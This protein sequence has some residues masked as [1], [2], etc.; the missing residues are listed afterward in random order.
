MRRIESFCTPQA[1]FAKAFVTSISFISAFP[2]CEIFP[3][4]R[5]SDQGA[6]VVSRVPFCLLPRGA[7]EC[8]TC[9]PLP[10]WTQSLDGVPLRGSTSHPGPRNCSLPGAEPPRPSVNASPEMAHSA[11]I[12]HPAKEIYAWQP[13]VSPLSSAP[14]DIEASSVFVQC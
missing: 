4:P 5:V 13:S 8:G 9:V 11:D 12:P 10:L 3:V 2:A 1:S 6:T 14:S 7:F